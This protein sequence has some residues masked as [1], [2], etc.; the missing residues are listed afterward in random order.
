MKD[1]LVRLL[2]ALPL[3]LAS[4]LASTA[5]PDLL[6]SI[7]EEESLP[8]VSWAMVYKGRAQA[9]GKGYAEL[10]S[11]RLMTA[12]TKVQV[13]SIT[14]TLVAL[15]ILHLVSDDQLD[16]DANVEQLLPMLHWDNPWRAETPVTVRHLLE[17]TAGLDNI[18]MWQFL[19][20]G[21]TA[22]T[23]LID[24]FPQVHDELLRI[25]TRPGT[26]YS[27]SNMGYAI[28]G[29]VIE[30]FTAERY[31]NYLDRELLEPLGMQDSSFRFITQNQDSRLAMGYLDAG[32]P[33]MA[34]P[35]FLRPAGQFTTTADDARLLLRFLL[36]DGNI[37]GG[38]FIAPEYLDRLG[39]PSTTDAY[40]SGLPMGHGLAL[41]SRDRHGVL[42]ECHPG[43]TFGFRAFLCV[44][45]EQGKAFFYAVNADSEKAD[46]ERLTRYFIEQIHVSLVSEVPPVPTENLNEYVGLYELAP[47]N[48]AEFAWLDWMF[49]SVWLSVDQR[50][51]GL[52][53]HSLQE[54]ERILLP[55][56]G[57]LFRDSD[58]GTASH[59]FFGDGYGKL[60]NG[61]TTWSK[62]SPL[63]LCLGWAGLILGVLGMFYLVL[64]GNWLLLRGRI[65]ASSAIVPPWLCL[66]AFAL[67]AYLYT[68]QPFLRFGEATAASLLLAA[69]SVLLPISLCFSCYYLTRR[70]GRSVLDLC[71]VIASLQ[72]CLV[73][74][75]QGVM[76]LVFWQ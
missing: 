13:G 15:G 57:G 66:M 64:K 16:L 52:V 40:L 76:P 25:R 50:G 29:L 34:V 71:A 42:G 44:F 48:M 24:A 45:R 73:L 63:L 4:M 70:Q 35:M 21:V 8:G 9:G 72:L 58:R 49:N 2:W 51:D 56:G 1:F 3:F 12:T 27:Y 46:Y 11:A 68:T 26:Q 5:T 62:A 19:N 65:L 20:S 55:L 7:L 28:L 10:D 18:R 69:L 30:R 38:E 54:S 74:F 41:A 60:S 14:K 6:E 17:H 33:Q 36:G 32:I 47:S 53:M 67:P 31:E 39:S 43:N 75:S 59:V 61:L 22:D 23:P 37:N